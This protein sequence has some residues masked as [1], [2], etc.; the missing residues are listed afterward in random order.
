MVASERSR[1]GP[2][3]L[4][5]YGLPYPR[6]GPAKR[7]IL[8][9]SFPGAGGRGRRPVL[10]HHRPPALLPARLRPTG[11]CCRPAPAAR[12]TGASKAALRR[13]AVG[14]GARARESFSLRAEVPSIA[15]ESTEQ[16]V[17]LHPLPPCSSCP[18]TLTGRG[19][20][21]GKHRLS[22]RCPPVLHI[23]TFALI[24]FLPT[25]AE[26]GVEMRGEDTVSAVGVA[27]W[28]GGFV[29][30]APPGEMRRVG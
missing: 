25:V 28:L 4:H 1:G 3:G 22:S 24:R 12:A 29:G 26:D 10:H 13:G 19:D 7:V 6:P 30:F 23:G 8:G 14:L 16:L 2:N 21:G 18:I 17:P 9:D 27:P 11:C 15:G 20:G 5:G